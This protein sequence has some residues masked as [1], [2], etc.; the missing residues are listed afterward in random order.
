MPHTLEQTDRLTQSIRGVIFAKS[1]IKVAAGDDKEQSFDSFEHVDPF[2][3]LFALS[4]HVK[5]AE[6]L[7]IITL[8]HFDL[9]SHF[10]VPGRDLSTAQDVVGG[11][12][13]IGRANVIDA[14]EEA[15]VA[16]QLIE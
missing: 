13:I 12:R 1:L 3:S 11:G 4:S 10:V 7:V 16:R 9:E 8:R 15:E 5:H 6:L 14:T 2:G